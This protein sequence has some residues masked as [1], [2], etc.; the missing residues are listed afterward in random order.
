M[1]A[2]DAQ[3]FQIC[4]A[5]IRNNRLLSPLAVNE[6][7]RGIVTRLQILP[8]EPIRIATK[9]LLVAIAWILFLT[10]FSSCAFSQQIS[11]VDPPA[12]AQNNRGTDATPQAPT[13]SPQTSKVP[14]SAP[15]PKRLDC[16]HSADPHRRHSG[17]K[18]EDFDWDEALSKS[19]NGVRFK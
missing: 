13:A 11:P 19:W 16:P 15:K 3:R 12:E 17:C 2:S 9:A 14:A 10:I 1:R 7:R 8:F 18:D 6:G 4:F 5:T